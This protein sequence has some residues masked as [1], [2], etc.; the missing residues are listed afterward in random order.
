MRFELEGC[1][2]SSYGYF[3]CLQPYSSV[4]Y[5]TFER[6]ATAI[7]I[8]D[9]C[10]PSLSHLSF[11]GSG[12]PMAPLM[13]SPAVPMQVLLDSTDVWI[14][15]GYWTSGSCTPDTGFVRTP[16]VWELVRTNVV[17]RKQS[18]QDAP[19]GE[20]GRVDLIVSGRL[21]TNGS[22]DEGDVVRFWP[23][24]P[25]AV[26]DSSAGG[27]WGGILFTSSASGS[28]VRYADVG[29]AANPIFMSYP[30]SLTLLEDSHI[31]SFADVG[32]WIQGSVG[33]GAVV[34]ECVVERGFGLHASLG[35][36]GIY[37]DNAEEVSILD[38]IVDL[39]GLETA[40]GGT[41]ISLGFTKAL[42]QTT[43]ADDQTLWIEDTY[44]FGPGTNLDLG[45][46][47]VG[48]RASWLCGGNERS[49]DIVGN[50]V[51]AWE[52]VG[53]EFVQSA[54]VTV[55]CNR[56]V[57]NRR[58]VDIYRDHEPTGA[59]IRFKHNALEALVASSEL[60]ALRTDDAVKTKLGPKTISERGQNRLSVN[61]LST[62]FIVEN[63]PTATDTLD[64]R[65]NFWF[66]DTL[67]ADTSSVTVAKI[68][69]R[70]AP[71]SA[72]VNF[73]GYLDDLALAEPL[74]DG[75]WLVAP[76]GGSSSMAAG[77][78]HGMAPEGGGSAEASVAAGPQVLE[79]GAP[80]PNPNRRGMAVALA[81]PA[82]AVG[83]YEAEI[84]DVAG[85]RVWTTRQDLGT[86][87]RYR[88]EWNGRS[89][90]GAELAAGIYFLRVRGPKGFLE[91]RKVSL[92]R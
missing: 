49:I 87:G 68:T 48:V 74:P 11:S 23:Q 63:D 30:D 27:D 15:E 75:C 38:S 31:H 35:T 81:V 84:F 29:Y 86:A 22:D 39:G 33:T 8:G 16:G 60:F 32:V 28:E 13:L 34:N 67:L 10:A 79:L 78:R 2:G 9:A 47:Y 57:G 6:A 26:T 66:A 85:R 42:C 82:E 76:G 1:R 20:V 73:Q 54:D 21:F 80:F 37:V 61:P 90:D 56:V 40:S 7:E 58:A 51:Q 62:N 25:T 44:V 83:R 14:P 50:W 45:D 92:L 19:V 77:G 69:S 17:A 43:P 70:I 52:K 41:G 88:V 4:A 59:A 36:T 3:G 71:D 53:M 72:L 46:D 55:G 89:Q 64:A 24:S 5:A 91:T 18:L 12:H 65:N